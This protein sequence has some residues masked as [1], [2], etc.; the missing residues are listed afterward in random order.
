MV[1]L[2]TGVTVIGLIGEHFCN[3][4]R[5]CRGIE[6]DVPDY[7]VYRFVCQDD[8]ISIIDNEY[9]GYVNRPV[10]SIN[11][12]RIEQLLLGKGIIKDCVAYMTGDGVLHVEVWQSKPVAALNCENGKYYLDDKGHCFPVKDD[13]CK[14][15]I[16][17]YGVRDVTNTVWNTR[18]AA[19]SQW[20]LGSARWQPLIEKLESNDGGDVSVYIKGREEVFLIGQPTGCEK[21]FGRMDQY[22]RKVAQNKKYNTVNVQYKGQIVCK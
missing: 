6:V 17:I 4:E 12:H 8:V 21:K 14:N 15:V 1:L 11:T 22:L 7:P 20:L 19:M 10:D 16:R 2:A 5:I 9:G 13:W 3:Q 18:V